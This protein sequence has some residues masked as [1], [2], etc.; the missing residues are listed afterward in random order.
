MHYIHDEHKQ[1][2]LVLVIP[3]DRQIEPHIVVMTRLEGTQVIVEI[4]TTDRPVEDALVAADI[5][6]HHI[7]VAWRGEK[8]PGT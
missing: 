3:N 6:R 2:D 8:T 4:D 1:L 7:L 5:P